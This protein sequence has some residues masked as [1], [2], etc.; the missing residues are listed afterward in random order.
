MILKIQKIT[1]CHIR[2]NWLAW[3][4][5]LTVIKFWIPIFLTMFYRQSV[6]IGHHE[7]LTIILKHNE[8]LICEFSLKVG[9]Y[10]SSWVIMSHYESSWVIMSHHE[11]L[12]VIMIHHDWL[13]F[14]LCVL[15]RPPESSPVFK[16]KSYESSWIIVTHDDSQWLIIMSHSH[17]S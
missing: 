17:D 11:S 4:H 14:Y 13:K 12:W 16:T 9:H 5:S 7:W 8:W 2:H 3:I 10:E 6:T 15:V 1:L